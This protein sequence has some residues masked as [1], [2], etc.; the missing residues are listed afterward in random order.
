MIDA[1]TTPPAGTLEQIEKNP[2]KRALEIVGSV[3]GFAVLT[4]VV[5][6]SVASQVQRSELKAEG[7]VALTLMLCAAFLLLVGRLRVVTERSRA[8][9][10]QLNSEHRPADAALFQALLEELHSNAPA[11]LLL[12]EHNFADAFRASDLSQLDAFASRWQVEERRFHD[13]AVDNARA[14]LCAEITELVTVVYEHAHEL[15][16]GVLTT[17]DTRVAPSEVAV[18]RCHG[19]NLRA[20]SAWEAHQSLIRIARERAVLVNPRLPTAAAA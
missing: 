8:L 6:K 16:N 15:P 17:W 11:A 7:L 2:V 4:A 14:I 9:R 20:R 5:I 18:R 13:A 10:Q 19:M 1:A 12:K 3:V